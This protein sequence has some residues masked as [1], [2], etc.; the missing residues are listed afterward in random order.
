MLLS[1][2]PEMVSV[3]NKVYC[4]QYSESFCGDVFQISDDVPFYTLKTAVN[5]IFSCTDLNYQHCLLTIDCNT[6]AICMI[7]EGTFKIFDCH[8]RD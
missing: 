7:S 5:K 8:S 4:L 1:D 2:V 6:V 3:D